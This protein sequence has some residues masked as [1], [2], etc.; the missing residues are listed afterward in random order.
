[1]N[2]YLDVL[3][4]YAG[5]SGRA[6]RKEYWMFAL[7]NAIV[8]VVLLAIGFAIESQIPYGIYMLAVL[9]PSLAVVVRRLHDTGRSGWWF[10]I[11]FV[12]LVGGIILLVF[13]C[14]EGAREANEY[15]ADPKLA[16]QGV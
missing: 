1:M 16:P 11:A 3:K 2:W 5:F 10:L 8:A 14:S 7:F 4:N 13:M 12:P 15:G 6:R 9:V